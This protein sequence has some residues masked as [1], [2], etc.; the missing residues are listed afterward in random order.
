MVKT[1]RAGALFR[2]PPERAR[3]V[4]AEAV[5]EPAKHGCKNK[6]VE[7]RDS[8]KKNLLKVDFVS[9]FIIFVFAK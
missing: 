2:L 5:V 8:A 4:A 1:A 6:F 9:L 3:R 7:I